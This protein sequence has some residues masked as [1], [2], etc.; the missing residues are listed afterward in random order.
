MIEFVIVSMIFCLSLILFLVFTGPGIYNRILALNCFGT[1]IVTFFAV[2]GFYNNIS[3][4]YDICFIYSL[5]NFVATI[6]FLKY[7]RLKNLAKE[8]QDDNLNH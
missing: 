8:L 5:I 1:L 2:L 4:Y 6:A 3:F 7:F